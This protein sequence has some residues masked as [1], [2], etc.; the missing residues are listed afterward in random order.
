MSTPSLTF[1]A[2]QPVPAPRSRWRPRFGEPWRAFQRGVGRAALVSGA[3][4]AGLTGFETRTGLGV[5]VDVVVLGLLGLALVWAG[6]GLTVLIWRLACL[7]ARLVARAL[8]RSLPA[9]VVPVDPVSL[10]RLLG[11]VFLAGCDRWLPFSPFANITLSAV[12]EL[13]MPFLWL[14][15]GLLGL[16]WAQ[17]APW[18]PLNR[19]QGT[20]LAAALLLNAVPLGWAALPGTTTG[21]ATA[22]LIP[23]QGVAALP[24][25]NPGLLGPFEVAALTYGSGLDHRPEFGRDAAL[26]APTVDAASMFPGLTGPLGDLRRWQWGFD[27]H[28]LPLNGRVWYP[29]DD[30]TPHP[31]VLIVHGNHAAGEAS[32]PGYTYLAEHLASRGYIA[33]SIDQ[34]FLNG[35]WLS[36]MNGEMPVRAWLLLKHLQQWR[37]WNETPGNPFYGQVDLDHVGLVGHSRGGEAVVHAA[38]LNMRAHLPVSKVDRPEA[39]GFGIRGVVA[40][41]PCDGQYQ[42]AGVGVTLHNASYLLLNGGHD[43]DT[44]TPYGLQQY[45]RVA[46]DENPDGFKAFVYLYRANHGQ[47]N[48]VWGD[49]DVGPI[50]STLLNRAPYLTGEEQRQAARVLITAFLDASVRDMSGYRAVFY[51]PDAARGWLPA[52]LYVTTYQDSGFQPLATFSPGERLATLQAAGLEWQRLSLSL[53]DGKT[54][55]RNSAAR[56]GWASAGQPSLTF[57]V[58]RDV[59]QPLTAQSALQFDLGVRGDVPSPAAIYVEAVD[60]AGTAARLPLSAFGALHPRLPVQSMKS[61]WL[62]GVVDFELKAVRSSEDLLQTYRVPLAAF[63]EAAP[64]LKLDSLAAVRLVFDAPGAGGVFVDEVGFV[65]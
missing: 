13:Y 57:E 55:Q 19:R 14:T 32:D 41:G 2:A 51:Q 1:P 36:P 21:L 44:H 39:F 31:L 11:A 65:P 64:S 8:R 35:D 10:G 50:K 38:E 48:T 46:F 61:D 30:S 58:P 62:S 6:E 7:V 42:P 45:H 34:N 9:R 15:G 52:D 18:L 5:V 56:L 20:L 17:G 12:A 24:L 16:A 27:M 25:E 63:A 26:T 29:S 40:I 23:A 43:G 37:T 47:F 4:A 3:L 49:A 28:A 59:V 53:R 22:E 33:V 54:P 60:V